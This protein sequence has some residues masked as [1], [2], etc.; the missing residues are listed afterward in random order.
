MGIER[1]GV[2][3]LLIFDVGLAEEGAWGDKQQVGSMDG[4][5][6]EGNSQV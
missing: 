2:S 4:K 1:N 3:C 6:L 5:T